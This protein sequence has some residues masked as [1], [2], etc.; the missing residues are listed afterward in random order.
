MLRLKTIFRYTLLLM[1]LACVTACQNEDADLSFEHHAGAYMILKISSGADTRATFD[2]DLPLGWEGGDGREVGHYHENDIQDFCF[3][4]YNAGGKLF[5]EA[6]P[7]TQIKYKRYISNVGFK[8]SKENEKII[9][10]ESAP[11]LLTDYKPTTGDRIIVVANMGD[12]TGRY[13][14]I[15]DLRD[16]QVSRA[17]TW[18]AASNIKDYRSFAMTSCTD[19]NDNQYNYGKVDIRP[20][21]DIYDPIVAYAEIERVAARVDWILPTNNN[22]INVSNLGAEYNVVDNDNNSVAT[23]YITDI[24]MVN[25]NQMPTYLIR[26]TA[27]AVNPLSNDVTYMGKVAYQSEEKRVPNRYVVEPNTTQKNNGLQDLT[28]FATWYG[29]SHYDI[30]SDLATLFPNGVDEFKVAKNAT[31]EDYFKV[32]NDWCYTIGY[33]MENVAEASVEEYFRF[34]TGVSLKCVYLPKEIYTYNYTEAHKNH[35]LVKLTG[36]NDYSYGRDFY[37]LQ[38]TNPEHNYFFHSQNDRA[39]FCYDHPCENCKKYDYIGGICYYYIPLKYAA[40]IGAESG[41]FPM[42]YAIVRN[43]IYRILIEKVMNIGTVEPD[44]SVVDRIRVH[45]WNRRLQPE[46][47]L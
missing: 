33:T 29:Q 45:E 36:E 23:L 28:M 15:G 25:D 46:I 22:D 10:Y 18:T 34:T 27:S 20:K 2:R 26:R 6:D 44:P 16:A 19:V 43:N 47:R 30:N 11:V 38:C 4:I 13:R 3:F 42:E 41:T 12:V 14:T 8:G 7:E 5:T 24:R 35:E 31:R 17:E 39:T 32:N 21:G 1:L 40:A 37:S 9:S